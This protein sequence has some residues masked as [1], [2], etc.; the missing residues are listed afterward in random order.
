MRWSGRP[1][2]TAPGVAERAPRPAGVVHPHTDRHALEPPSRLAVRQRY[3]RVT[4][5][6]GSLLCTDHPRALGRAPGRTGVAPEHRDPL[7]GIPLCDGSAPLR[8]SLLG[9][10]PAWR[11]LFPLLA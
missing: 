8:R 11:R 6:L 4:G 7:S 10:C 2:L 1:A 5:G 9:P 3:I